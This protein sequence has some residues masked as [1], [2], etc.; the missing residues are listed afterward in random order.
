MAYL[1]YLDSVAATS[2]AADRFNVSKI[3][4]ERWQVTRVRDALAVDVL[5]SRTHARLVVRMIL[6]GVKRRAAALAFD[7]IT[8]AA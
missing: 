8:P 2:T 1:A 4:A 6:D 3:S 5:P 7:D